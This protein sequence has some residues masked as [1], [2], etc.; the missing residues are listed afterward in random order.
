MINRWEEI[1][2]EA[3]SEAHAQSVRAAVAPQ[4]AE[5]RATSQ[6]RKFWGWLTATGVG[7]TAAA[8]GFAVVFRSDSAGE[9]TTELAELLDA[10]I[11]HEGVLEASLEFERGDLDALDELDFLEALTDE[12]L[13]RA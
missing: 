2:S 9:S 10:G 11:E 3:T 5:L 7:L 1:L 13:D 6:R 4:L 12:D 8:A